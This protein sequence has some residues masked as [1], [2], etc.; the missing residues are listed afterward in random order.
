MKKKVKTSLPQKDRTKNTTSKTKN[1]PTS[2]D[3]SKPETA[4]PQKVR[5]AIEPEGEQARHNERQ[6]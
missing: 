6:K 4:N 3:T 2:Y 5:E 1:Q